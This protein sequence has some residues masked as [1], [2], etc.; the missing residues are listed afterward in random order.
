MSKFIL[1]DNIPIQD[2]FFLN[3]F[4]ENIHK[5]SKYSIGYKSVKS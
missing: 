2:I 5:F 3:L 4:Q 1:K